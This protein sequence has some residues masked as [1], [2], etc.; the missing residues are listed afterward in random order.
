M[1]VPSGSRWLSINTAALSSKRMYEPS[2]RPMARTVRT[3]TAL[4][5]SP[6]LTRAFGMAS[7]TLTTITSPIVA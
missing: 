7:F 4:R 3:T 6:F 1:R 2:L 5:T